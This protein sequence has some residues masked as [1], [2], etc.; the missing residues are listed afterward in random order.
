M[1]DHNE[2]A[3]IVW[4]AFKQSM[5]VSTNSIVHFDLA[6]LIESH[7]NLEEL[8]NSFTVDEIED[9]AP[10][11]DGFNGLFMKKCW[12]IIRE[13]FYALCAQFCNGS[14]SLESLNTSLIT[15][16]PKR[17]NPEGVNDRPI[18]LLSILL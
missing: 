4:S 2:K 18:S 15:L 17:Q 10:G 3:S 11:A 8:S 9:K 6:S 16:V 7:D 5:E 14:L 12:S 13:D 1:T